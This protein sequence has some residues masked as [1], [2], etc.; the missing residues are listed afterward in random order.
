VDLD[1][2]AVEVHVPGVGQ[3]RVERDQ[4]DWQPVAGHA[5]LTLAVSV[6]FHSIFGD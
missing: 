5:P 3:A 6:L 4:L 1:A 2:R